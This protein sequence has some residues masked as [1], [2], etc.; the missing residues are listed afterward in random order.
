[1]RGKRRR[2]K[3]EEGK[4]KKQKGKSPERVPSA[5]KGIGL[6]CA[7]MLSEAKHPELVGECLE[8]DGL[9]PA[10]GGGDPHPN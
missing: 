6:L 3:K 2:A 10:Y 8:L 4:R 7:V 9:T 5:Q 1:M